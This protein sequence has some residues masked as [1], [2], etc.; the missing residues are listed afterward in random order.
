MPILIST[1]SKALNYFDLKDGVDCLEDVFEKSL[2]EY[3][4][5]SFSSDWSYPPKMSQEIIKAIY[6][7]GIRGSYIN[8][9]TDK[10][11]DA[12]LLE[13]EKL[14]QIIKPFLG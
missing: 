11:H 2:C 7:A 14:K 4:I 1:I 5:L 3:L 6:N 13:T 8:I 9:D 12:F 10:G